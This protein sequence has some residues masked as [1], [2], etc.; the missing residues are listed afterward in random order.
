MLICA[1][2]YTRHGVDTGAVS[3]LSLITVGPSLSLSLS[4]SPSVSS[5]LLVFVRYLEFCYSSTTY[6][7]KSD[8]I[9]LLFMLLL[10]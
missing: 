4:I 9:L 3:V 8:Y 1:M 10:I 6:L 7:M 5:V 2:P